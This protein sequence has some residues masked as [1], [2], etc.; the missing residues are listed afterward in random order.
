MHNQDKVITTEEGIFVLCEREGV[1][2]PHT[3]FL[4][5]QTNKSGYYKNCKY[6]KDVNF[7]REQN[8]IKLSNEILEG[9]GYDTSKDIHQQFLKK[10][11][12]YFKP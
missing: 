1:Y 10:N 5:H 11:E 7:I 3:D 8:T 2:K 6:C 4:K 12:Q 9:L